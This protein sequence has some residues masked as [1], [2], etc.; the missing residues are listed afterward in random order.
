[1]RP[2]IYLSSG[3]ISVGVERSP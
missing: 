1:M 3:M 2:S